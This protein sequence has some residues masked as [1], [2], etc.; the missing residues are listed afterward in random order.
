MTPSSRA[1]RALQLGVVLLLG[2]AAGRLSPVVVRP[3]L[4]LGQDAA[5]PGAAGTARV[6]LEWAPQPFINIEPRGRAAGT[7]LVFYGGGL[8]RPQAYEWLGRALAA[9]GV[10]T[11]IPVFPLDLAVTG[12]NRAGSLIGRFG[13][14]KRVVLAGHSLG[15]AV[16]AGYAAEQGSS[17]SGLVLLAAYPARNVDLRAAPFPVLSLLAA[18]D[19]VA[20]AEDVRGGLDRLPPGTT[21]TV[22]PGAVH[23]FFGRYGPQRGD[24]LPDVT[25]EQ[26]EREIV[27][28]V[29]GFLDTLPPR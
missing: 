16:A 23:A 14:G 7:L 4:V 18:R 11:V 20:A 6:T 1:R 25:R 26:T 13:A 27:R 15:G 12:V 8:V 10:Q 21:L 5:Y 28:A 17:L 29:G 19:G 9:R 2:A 22:L 24:G 3:P